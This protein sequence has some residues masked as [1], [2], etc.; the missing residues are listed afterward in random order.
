MATFIAISCAVMI[1]LCVPL[2]FWRPKWVFYIFLVSEVFDSIFAGYINH[3]SNLGLPVT[4]SPADF[5][6]VMTLAAAFFV[7]QDSQF[8]SGLIKKCII[9][10]AVL[11]VIS[12]IQGFLMYPRDA[13]TNSRVVHFIAAGIFALRYFTNY[14]RVRGLIRFSIVIIFMMFIVHIFIRIGIY[15]APINEADRII[16]AGGLIGERGT[17]ALI[18]MLYLVLVSLAMGRF[19]N[20]IGW[21]F[22][23]IIMLLVGLG[24]IVLSETR[25]TY[26]AMAV[27]VISALVF[28]R[29]RI[30]NTIVFATVGMIV[31]IFAVSSGFDFL[32]RFRTDYGRGYYAAPTFD[33]LKNSWRGIEYETI[34][35]SFKKMP[36]F[37]LT[38]RGIGAM[39]PA[40]TGPTELV[41]FYHSEYLGWFDRCGLI[42][43]FA[44]LFLFAA[45]LFRSFALAR[46]E[47]PS[48]QYIGTT[49][50]LL[51][52]ALAADGIFH[53]IFS[54]YRGSSLLISFV[55]VAANWRDIYMSLAE[56]EE[57]L[58]E[59][60]DFELPEKYEPDYDFPHV[61]A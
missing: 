40:P 56:D 15:S 51:T 26:G 57:M 22:V 5:L 8:H 44:I 53:P 61:I 43:L 24:G 45:I 52:I 38:G 55:A 49:L 46:S 60:T 1:V 36:Y 23:S 34:R 17:Q 47:I 48:L 32:A 27:L 13:L 33:E 25:S 29:S 37:L 21:L 28:M 4:W 7:K 41:A 10:L 6:S 19:I 39:H 2:I 30:K 54:H 35:T 16:A 3:A 18:P 14:S 12:L 50:F 9:V 59:D 20:K 11:S 58:S 42:G 31:V